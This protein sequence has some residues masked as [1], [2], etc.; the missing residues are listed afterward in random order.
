MP[1]VLV[2][3]ARHL[4]SGECKTGVT[5]EYR[6]R[7][8][9]REHVSLRVKATRHWVGRVEFRV[10]AVRKGYPAASRLAHDLERRLRCIPTPGW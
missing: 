10:V 2:Y 6:W 7:T 1:T 9:V 5:A 3:I 8:R 4:A